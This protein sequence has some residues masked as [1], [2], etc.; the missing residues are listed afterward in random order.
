MID[1][2]QMI[3]RYPAVLDLGL[4]KAA[5]DRVLEHQQKQLAAEAVRGVLEEELMGRHRFP[6][7]EEIM[8]RA[9]FAITVRRDH[10]VEDTV[11]AIDSAGDEKLARKLMV[12]IVGEEGQDEG[13]VSRGFFYSLMAQAF[14]RTSG[15]SR[16]C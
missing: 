4:K 13:G 14:R 12:T 9:R 8:R 6:A 11:R 3:V 10:L 16:S 15:C 2:S 7:E 5:F 1:P